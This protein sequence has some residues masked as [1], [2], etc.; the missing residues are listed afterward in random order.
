MAAARRWR[1]APC[2]DSGAML[3]PGSRRPTRFAHFV[4]CAQTAGGQSVHAARCARRPR[5]CASRRHPR[6]ASHTPPAALPPLLRSWH[7][8][9]VSAYARPGEMASCVARRRE[10]QGVRLGARRALREL[11]GRCLFERSERSERQRVGRP[12]VHS[13]IAG[14]LRAAQTAECCTPAPARA[15]LDLAPSRKAK[16]HERN[17]PLLDVQDFCLEFRTRSGTVPA[18]QGVDLA[19]RRAR[20]SLV[21][22]SGSG[23]SVLSYAL[24]RIS[25]RARQGHQRQC[26]VRRPRPAQGRRTYPR[27]PACPRDL[28]DPQSPRTALNP[29]SPVGAQIEDVLRRHA[30]ARGANLSQSLRERSVQALREVAISD[31]ER[32]H[33]AYPFE[34]SGGMCQRV[35]IA[36]ALACRP[37]ALDRRRAHHGPGRDHASRR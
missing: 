24:I 7:A 10:A 12:A 16:E 9:T 1:S 20:S 25:D 21:G 30:A 28:D 5:P 15:R 11:T 17:A 34:M 18:L 23:M 32:R 3:E 33:S 31:P 29:I 13:S 35:M 36:L 37:S 6:A 26:D 14:C 4:R 22:E 8:T 19:S 2:A 27:R